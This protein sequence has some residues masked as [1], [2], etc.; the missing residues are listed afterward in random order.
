MSTSFPLSSRRAYTLVEVIC[1]VVLMGVLAGV[2]STFLKDAVPQGRNNNAI[3]LANSVNAAKKAYELR[4]SNA[5][6]LW[7]GAADDSARFLL[8]RDRIPFAETLTLAQFVPSGYTFSL[9]SSLATRVTI[10]GPT[11]AVAY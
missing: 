9:G 6:T 7:S 1:V 11:G 5:S 4:V 3:A 2:T 10:V 8:I